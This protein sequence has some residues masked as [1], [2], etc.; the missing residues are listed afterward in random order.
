MPRIVVKITVRNNGSMPVTKTLQKGMIVEVAQPSSP[1]QHAMVR[2]DYPVT[3]PPNASVTLYIEAD[4]VDRNRRWPSG[5]A[6]NLTPFRF[7]GLT[8]DQDD[9]WKQVSP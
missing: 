7:S 1:Y 9:L 3:I 4:S 8:K 2:R 6:G 5:V